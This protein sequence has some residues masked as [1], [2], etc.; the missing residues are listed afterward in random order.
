M[1][2][3][4]RLKQHERRIAALEAPEIPTSTVMQED[5]DEY[6]RRGEALEQHDG[7][8]VELSARLDELLGRLDQYEQRLDDIAQ[9]IVDGLEGSVPGLNEE[10]SE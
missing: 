3:Y 8:L 5:Y 6:T 4:A 2:T 7:R 9:R 1:D 10:E